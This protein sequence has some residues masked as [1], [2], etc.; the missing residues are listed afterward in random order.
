MGL[1]QIFIRSFKWFY[2]Y[3]YLVCFLGR[4]GEGEGRKEGGRERE[5]S[6]MD[7]RGHL[8][9]VGSLLLPWTLNTGHQAWPQ[10]LLPAGPSCPYSSR[11]F[12]CSAVIQNLFPEHCFS[13]LNVGSWFWLCR[14]AG[15]LRLHFANMGPCVPMLLSWEMHFEHHV[16]SYWCT[17]YVDSSRKWELEKDVWCSAVT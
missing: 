14:S 17:S 13:N 2:F 5:N 1:R 3:V 15:D 9:E 7:D 12:S 4:D 16:F 8:E 6:C 11:P 10:T